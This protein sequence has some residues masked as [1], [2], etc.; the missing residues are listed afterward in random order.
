VSIGTQRA[1]R[2]DMAAATILVID[3]NEELL[4]L[5]DAVLR[6]NG[7]AVSTLAEPPTT[8]EEIR[9]ARPD[10]II[11]DLHFGGQ[12]FEGWRVLQ[13]LRNDAKLVD[14]PVVVC[15][16]GE[17][18]V[19]DAGEWLRRHNVWVL[20]KPFVVG[21]LERTLREALQRPARS[22]NQGRQTEF[23]SQ[24]PGEARS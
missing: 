7:Y 5:Y 14:L 13:L 11:L 10:A 23:R 15:T 1:S 6:Y 20:L 21:D 19:R 9:R 4:T 3:D 18:E 22:L 12:Q 8:L 17:A 2:A 16:A 24:S